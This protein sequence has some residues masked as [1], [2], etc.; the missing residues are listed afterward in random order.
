MRYVADTN[1]F[2]LLLDNKMSLADLPSDS[3]LVATPVQIDEIKQTRDVQRRDQ[4]LRMFSMVFP[5]MLPTE[6]ANW[7]EGRLWGNESKWSDGKLFESIVG[8]LD[9]KQK[10]PNNRQ[11]ARIAEVA[12]ANGYGLITGD[13]VLAHVMTERS[14]PVVFIQQ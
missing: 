8:S 12:E 7:G 13:K 9:A 3:E 4:L 1:V 5:T 6:S 14:V 11:D 2:N 10:K